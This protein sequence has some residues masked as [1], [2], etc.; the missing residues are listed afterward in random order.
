MWGQTWR[1]IWDLV[2]PPEFR[3]LASPRRRSFFSGLNVTDM[4]RSAEDYY[5]SMGLPRMTASFW[6]NSQFIRPR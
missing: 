6:R 4:V 1:N 3:E 5:A 2:K